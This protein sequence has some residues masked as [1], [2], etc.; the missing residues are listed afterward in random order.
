MSLSAR[1][2]LEFAAALVTAGGL[3]DLLTPRLPSNL[4]LMCRERDRRKTCSRVVARPGS[5]PDSHRAN[6]GVSPNAIVS[7]NE[8]SD[9]RG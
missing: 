8:D 6:G 7:F 3:Y 9:V 2:F 5:L 1:F 4:E